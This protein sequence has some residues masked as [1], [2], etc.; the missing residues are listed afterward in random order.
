[1]QIRDMRD[2]DF[3]ALLRLWNDSAPHDRLTAALLREK[4]LDDPDVGRAHCLVADG[5]ESPAGFGIGLVRQSPEARRGFVKMLAVAPARRRQGIGRRILTRLESALAKQ[6]AGTIRIAE[7][8]PNYLV[9][10]IDVRYAEGVLF[11]ESCGYACI[12]EARNLA[13]QNEPVTLH[14]AVCEQQLLGF[15]A[16]DANNKGTGWFGPMGVRGDSRHAGIGC[17]LLRACLGD[18]RKQG[19]RVATIP[20]VDAIPF[21]E[22]CAGATPSRTFLRFEKKARA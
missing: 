8:A 22:K 13:L 5:G 3:E 6:G 2:D 12:G 7:S 21:Y 19:H 11:L 4:I 10:G 1:M 20:W 18:I 15:A 9:P 14:L 16:Y 17:A